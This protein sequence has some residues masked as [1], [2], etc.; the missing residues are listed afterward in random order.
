[1]QLFRVVLQLEKKQG[2]GN[3]QLGELAS[4]VQAALGL[5][6]RLAEG[7]TDERCSAAWGCRIRGVSSCRVSVEGVGFSRG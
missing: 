1:M 3:E 2:R 4:L 6:L 7:W 5:L